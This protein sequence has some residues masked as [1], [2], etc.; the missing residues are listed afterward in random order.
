LIARSR[1]R[2]G[3]SALRELVEA[4]LAGERN[5][6]EAEK[7]FRALVKDAKFPEPQSNA[8]VGPFTV[9]FLWPEERVVAELDGFT[10][11]R[12]R[13]A[14]EGDRARDGDLQALGYRVVRVTWRQLTREPH[15]V[16]ARVAAVLALSGRE[17]ARV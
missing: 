11:H 2:P 1:G 16:V 12:T 13:S 7:R 3:I 5:R 14:F 4:E 6:L 9:D 17:L 10:T 15:A 8:K